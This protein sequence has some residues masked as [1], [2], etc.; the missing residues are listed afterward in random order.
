MNHLTYPALAAREVME[1]RDYLFHRLG[2]RGGPIAQRVQAFATDADAIRRALAA[3]Y[4]H[5]CDLWEDARWL[6]R[7]CGPARKSPVEA[8]IAA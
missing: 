8:A 4:P 7:F 5:G 2:D 6:G 1:L 3:D